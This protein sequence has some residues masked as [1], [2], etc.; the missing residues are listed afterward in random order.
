MPAASSSPTRG[1]I[2]VRSSTTSAI[3]TSNTRSGIRSS[4]PTASNGSGAI[5]PTS[6]NGPTLE[7]R[8]C[9]QDA[10]AELVRSRY[11]SLAQAAVLQLGAR[12]DVAVGY[13]ATYL[14][15]RGCGS[16]R[17]PTF[18]RRGRRNPR[19]HLPRVSA[20]DG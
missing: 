6:L 14:R 5:R 20:G 4:P 16:A 3:E 15:L 10:A 18:R 1:T 19:V 11:L 7:R 8:T 13:R 12:G 2:P 17:G 9:D